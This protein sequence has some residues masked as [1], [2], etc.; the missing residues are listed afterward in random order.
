MTATTLV[1]SLVAGGLMVATVAAAPGPSHRQEV[2]K[3]RAKHEADYRKEYVGLAGL[4]SI[5]PKRIRPT[6]SGDTEWTTSP[7][8]SPG[9][10][11][12]WECG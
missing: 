3:W 7:R 12:D 6:P 8:S 11:E 2:E 5:T 9:R 1:F 10:T 4:F